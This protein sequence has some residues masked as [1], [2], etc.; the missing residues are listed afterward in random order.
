MKTS[1]KLMN[2]QKKEQH[3]WH[4]DYVLQNKNAI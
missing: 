4:D 3:H 2:T 1:F